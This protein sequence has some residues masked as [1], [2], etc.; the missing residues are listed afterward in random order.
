[1]F[2]DIRIDKLLKKKML[3]SGLIY[4][5]IIILNPKLQYWSLT[6]YFKNILR[7]KLCT[8]KYYKLNHLTLN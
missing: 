7:I 5:L 3:E 2:M 1:M 4:K 8:Y 6:K